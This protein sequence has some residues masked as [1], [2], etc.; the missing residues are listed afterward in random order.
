MKQKLACLTLCL[1]LCCAGAQ[2]QK[3]AFERKSAHRANGSKSGAQASATTVQGQKKTFVRE[4]AYQAGEDDSRNS[5]RVN[6]TNQMRSILLREVVGEFLRVGR[7]LEQSATSQEYKERIEAITAGVVAMETLEER[8]DGSTYYIKA[9]MTVDPKDLERRIA[10]LLND[11]SKTKELEDARKRILAAEAEIARWKK[12]AEA[13][14]N[15]QQRSA[16]QQKYQQSVAALSAEEYFTRA[17]N[18]HENEFYDLA[19]EYYQKTIASDPNHAIAYY[20]MGN[21]YRNLENYQEA[22]RCYQKAI[23]IDPK[24]ANAY[25]NMGT[26]YDDLKNHQEA[27]RCYQKAIAIDPKHVYAYYNMGN[28]YA[29]LKN[30]QEVI[31][32]YQK[33]IAIDPQYASAYNN[34]GIAYD[35]LEN[36]QEAI[37]CY[38]KA[39]AI[40]PKDATAYYN[41]GIAYRNLENYQEAIRCYQKIIAIDPQNANAY[42]NMGLAY[43]NLENYQEAIRCYQKIIDIGSNDE[44]AYSLLFHIAIKVSNS[45][46][47]Q[48]IKLYDILI[49]HRTSI[50]DKKLLATVYNNKAYCLVELGDYKTALPLVNEALEIESGLSFIWDTKG[51]ACYHLG[52]YKQCIQS[53][54]KAI[55]ITDSSWSSFKGSDHNNAYYQRGLA[56]IR[57]GQQASGYQDIRTAAKNGMEEAIK[58]LREHKY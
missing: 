10:E 9:E 52:L 58:Y 16:L 14:K 29:N 37:R 48:A 4:Y 25:G 40:D 51:E 18:A 15:E 53:M 46:R 33:A 56:K 44:L 28:A 12:E 35:N 27:I 45:D 24:D 47:R 32:C 42:G 11:K 36:Y 26:A 2:A 43:Y 23:A 54:D 13:A 1:L 19:I 34:M 7:T 55:S 6:A 49:A 38:Q 41:M 17:Y 30:Y 22:I 39:I 8:W 21:A 50:A 31:R 3:K 20:N 57:L 5:A